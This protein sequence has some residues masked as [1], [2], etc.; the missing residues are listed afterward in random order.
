MNNEL[1]EIINELPDRQKE[2]CLLHFMEGLK[3]VDIS[4][5][6]NISVNTIE[7]HISRALKTLRQKIRQ[8]T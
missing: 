4:E 5:R 8:Y 1:T 6:L 7:N 3:Y 2:V